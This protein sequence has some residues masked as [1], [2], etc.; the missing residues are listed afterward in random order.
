MRYSFFLK[1]GHYRNGIRFEIDMVRGT[2]STEHD[3]APQPNDE[4]FI[5]FAGLLKFQK[6]L[7]ECFPEQS[8]YGGMMGN[9]WL[10]RFLQHII[11]HSELCERRRKGRRGKK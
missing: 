1:Y 2:Y 6:R 4:F 9:E 10:I 3:A 7:L 11:H 5:G 8:S